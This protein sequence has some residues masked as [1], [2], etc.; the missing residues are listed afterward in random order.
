[1]FGNAFY[2][3]ESFYAVSHGRVNILKPK[4]GLTKNTALFI[5][6][7]IK[8]EQ[9]KYSYGRAV[10]SN[11]AENIDIKLPIKPNGEPDFEFMEKYINSLHIK[12]LTTKNKKEQA[13]NLNISKWKEFRLEELFEIVRGDRIV[14]NVDYFDTQD[15]IYQYP[16]ITTTTTDNG[17]DGYYEKANCQGNCIISGGEANGL[18][19][20][21]QETS[22]WVLDTARI[23]KPKGFTMNKYLGL[24]FA[25]ELGYNMYRFS[26]GRK[27]KPSNMYSLII[28]LPVNL[29]GKPNFEFMKNYI[30]SLPYGDKI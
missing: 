29:N 13:P 4:F 20:T 21:Y 5:V 1:M 10:Y 3:D 24:F 8:Q 26:Y 19:T 18:F 6:T 12:P 22:C 15:E 27:A 7:I 30:K 23:Y 2:Q 16:V 9:Y 25:T 11:V 14:R 17:V 28:K